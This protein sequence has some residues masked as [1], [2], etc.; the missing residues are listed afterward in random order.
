MNPE[1]TRALSD[2]KFQQK[3]F[4]PE[5]KDVHL[6]QFNGSRF[7]L[8][9]NTLFSFKIDEMFA[10]L[11][12]VPNGMA[13]EDVKTRMYAKYGKEEVDEL[14]RD[15]GL[16]QQRGLFK[17]YAEVPGLDYN[18]HIYK[19]SLDVNHTCNLGCLYCYSK[20]TDTAPGV[21]KMNEETAK[22]AIDFLLTDFG[23]DAK[24]YEVNIVGAG[25][26]LLNFELIKTLREYCQQW[27]KELNKRIIFWV[28]TNGTVFT[29]EM[30]RYFVEQKQR[31]TIS[32]DGPKELHDALRPFSNGRGS[33]DIIRHWIKR[34]KTTAKGKGGLEN[35]WASAIISSKHNQLKEVLEE[36][37][38]LGIVNAQIRPIRTV[39]K[40]LALSRDNISEIKAAYD[41]LVGFLL[42][43]TLS[44]DLSYIKV[45]LTQ[46]DF[47]GRHILRLMFRQGVRYR[48]DAAK[49]MICVLANGDIYPCDIS[50]GTL[51]MKLGSLDEG[52]NEEI[53]QRYLNLEVSQKKICRDCWARYLCGGGCYYSAFIT[54]GDI[55]QPDPAI[56]ELVKHLSELSVVF[57][58]EIQERD[59]KIAN[60]LYRYAEAREKVLMERMGIHVAV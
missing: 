6:F 42:E 37:I 58:N 40:D 12:A 27:E 7:A 55:D 18:S 1:R 60:K 16:L 26:P 25:E 32:I 9:A 39:N 45:I 49:S 20:V 13:V 57:L 14:V 34:I 10:D 46:R 5:A 47:L 36:F 30:I 17:T 53:R 43:K 31:L 29:E 35:L 54:N 28:F 38:S 21:G 8:D 22:R 51:G 56:C 52:I 15:F 2:G 19:L 33:Y 24:A 11:L 41:K 23:K 50:C 44:G 48:C 4:I 3:G 59:E